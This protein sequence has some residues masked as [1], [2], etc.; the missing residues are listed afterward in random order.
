MPLGFVKGKT[1]M[2]DKRYDHYAGMD[3]FKGIVRTLT[4]V[5][6]GAHTYY[7]CM[8]RTYCC[9]IRKHNQRFE[10]SA[11]AYYVTA[12][13][14]YADTP[15]E[16]LLLAVEQCVPLDLDLR[17]QLLLGHLVLLEEA[18][19]STKR[20]TSLLEQLDALLALIDVDPVE[21][22]D[23]PNYPCENCIGM[24]QHGCYCQAMGCPAPGVPPEEPPAKP[25]VGYDED[26]DL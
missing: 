26:D 12:G 18:I 9:E 14:K 4:K 1:Y 7:S 20:L 22:D 8:T 5:G 25:K 24:V 23:E 19:A 11:H 2:L 6:F 3:V 21:E 17:K 10:R 16:A 13:H 15:L